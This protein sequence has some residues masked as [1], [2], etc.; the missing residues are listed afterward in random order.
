MA[1]AMPAV[2]TVADL[3]VAQKV[4]SAG[5]FGSATPHVTDRFNFTGGLCFPRRYPRHIH[6]LRR[7]GSGPAPMFPGMPVANDRAQL[8]RRQRRH[9]HRRGW[10]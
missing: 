9:F 4:Q 7:G 5:L 3:G 8:H 2:A 10:R 1:M 6:Y